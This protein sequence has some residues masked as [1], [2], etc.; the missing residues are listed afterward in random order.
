MR[1]I[2]ELWVWFWILVRINGVS[3]GKMV[4]IMEGIIVIII[5]YVKTYW[6]ISQIYE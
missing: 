4:E 1:G 2:M 3:F 5:S 6:N